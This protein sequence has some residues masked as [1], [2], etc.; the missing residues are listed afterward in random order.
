MVYADDASAT[1][2][3]GLSGA[4]VTLTGNPA[5]PYRYELALPSAG[6]IPADLTYRL[7]NK[8]LAAVRSTYNAL[9]EGGVGYLDFGTT[10]GDFDLG[11]WLW[12]STVK[13]PVERVEYYSPGPVQWSSSVRVTPDSGGGPEQRFQGATRSYAK[14]EKLTVDWNKPVVGP[15]FGPP[16]GRG[17]ARPLQAFRNA[18][19][20]DVLLPLFSDSDG[21]T[22]ITRPEEDSFA[23]QGETSL[24]ADGRLLARTELPGEGVFTV[25]PGRAGYR[26]VSE[27]RRS[28]PAWPL[29]TR[30]S[31]DWT[32]R[33][34][35]TTEPKPLPLLTVRLDPKLDLFNY[36][37]AGRRFAIPVRVDRQPGTTGGKATLKTV[38]VSYNDG[39]TW[40][41][42]ELVQV[43]SGWRAMVTHPT[44]GFVSLRSTATD[45]DGNRVTQTTIHAYRLK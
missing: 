31:A 10:V 41:P 39:A 24:Y 7:R 43:G 8:D 13:L 5:S 25:Q 40:I 32:F 44:S 3:A 27:V 19:T 29:A 16:V 6:R 4:Q 17:P 33:S 26:L 9:T 11:G 20:V 30:V 18:N 37:P 42:A 15:A 23:D 35:A 36:A 21:H 45:A 22:G 38:D 2:L 12:S 1:R 34:A 14:G 28:S